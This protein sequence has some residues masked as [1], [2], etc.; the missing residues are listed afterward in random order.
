MTAPTFKVLLKSPFSQFS[1]YGQD[2]LGLARAL[3]KWGCDVYLQ[4]TWIDV[5]VPQDLLPLLTK[6]LVPPFDLIINHWDPDNLG[7]AVEAR[8]CARM[9]VAWTMWEFAPGPTGISGLVP[10]SRF[11][12]SLRERLKWY[13]LVLGY[14]DVT[15][16]SLAPYIPDGVAMGQLIG[17]YES[18]EWKYAQRDWHGEFMFGMHGALNN[19]KQPYLTLQAFLAL[20]EEHPEEFAS[21]RLAFHT[22]VPPLFPE[23]NEI[24]K[25]RRVKVFFDMWDHDTLQDF[26]ASC[27]CLVY[28]S[29][30]EGK[31]VPCLEH[32]TTG[33]V[34]IHTNYGGP[35]QWLRDDMSYPL[36]YEMVPVF[37]KYPNAAHW[38]APAQQDLQDLMW[39]V[40]THRDEARLKGDLAAKL[41]PSQLDWAFVAEDLFRRIRDLCPHPGGEIYNLAM[42]ARRNERKPELQQQAGWGGGWSG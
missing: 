8:Q 14:D 30:G 37:E 38:A 32:M 2:G 31:N 16:G 27:H 36:K 18:S 4:P 15:M 41:I 10:H 20:K 9:A 33:G 35:Q 39:H 17:G 7:I 22:T 40:F 6:T 13:D 42:A 11:H 3:H 19:R 1:G 24:L 5:P 34:V 23:L 28:P 29:R 25:D 21:A 12:S 26:Y